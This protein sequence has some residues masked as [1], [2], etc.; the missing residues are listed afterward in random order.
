MTNQATENRGFRIRL[1]SRDDFAMMHR[2]GRLAAECL[3]L[4]VE[5]AQPGVTT[6]AH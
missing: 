2:A 3:D 5:K 6:A 4:L 1:H